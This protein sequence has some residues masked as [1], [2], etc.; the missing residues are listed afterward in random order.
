[1][2]IVFFSPGS[3]IRLLTG[4]LSY[5]K[6]KESGM[7]KLIGLFTLSLVASAA[8]N[9]SIQDRPS[10]GWYH[11]APTNAPEIDPASALSGLTMLAGGLAV[12]RGRRYKK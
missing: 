3:A 2:L 6:I 9:A 5:K 4:Q 10:D 7:L 12:L 11:S 1:L 8:A